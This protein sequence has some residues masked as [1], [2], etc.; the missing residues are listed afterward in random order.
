VTLGPLAAQRRVSISFV[1]DRSDSPA[2]RVPQCPN[3]VATPTGGYGCR[4]GGSRQR[5]LRYQNSGGFQGLHVPRC[6]VANVGIAC[7]EDFVV[8]RIQIA[9]EFRLRQFTSGVWRN[10]GVGGDCL[11]YSA[12]S[13]PRTLATEATDCPES[14]FMTRTPVASR[15]WELISRT[16]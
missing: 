1:N 10:V 14:R 9:A 15:P 5:P 6:A 2:L 7:C 16:A 12:S 4:L 11:A 3:V 13:E 8:R